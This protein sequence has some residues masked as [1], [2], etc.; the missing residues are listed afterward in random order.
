MNSSTHSLGDCG[1]I[2][3]EAK[4]WGD[5]SISMT[6]R[7]ASKEQCSRLVYVKMDLVEI[8]GV[9]PASHQ[10]IRPRIGCFKPIGNGSYT[11]DSNSEPCLH[12]GR[13]NFRQ[14][15]RY[16]LTLAPEYL[17]CLHDSPI[18]VA[19]YTRPGL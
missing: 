12:F 1:P 4:D 8:V 19:I 2:T 11:F 6:L 5:T 15:S 18:T 3:I 9:Q 17:L 7:F 16:Q 14:C 10:T 13:L